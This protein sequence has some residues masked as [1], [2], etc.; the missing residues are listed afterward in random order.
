MKI[1]TVLFGAG[2]GARTF[3]ANTRETRCFVGVLDNDANKTGSQFEGLKV[4][5]PADVADL[6]F[7]EIVIT[8]QWALPVKKQL[9]NDIGIADHKVVIPAKHLLKKS[10]PFYNRKSLELG[11]YI[12]RSIS[13]LAVSRNCDLLVDFGTLLGLIRDKDI[14]EWDDDIDFAAPVSQCVE[15]EQILQD[16]IARS[17]QLQIDWKLEKVADANNVVSSLLL[18]FEANEDFL[19][20]TTSFSFREFKDGFSLHM[21]SLGMWHAPAC[22]FEQSERIAWRGSTVQVPYKYRD[23]LTFQYGKWEQPQ[24]NMSLND[25]ANLRDIGFEEI[26]GAGRTIRTITPVVS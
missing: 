26:R 25:Y 5:L 17:R 23:Y 13:D 7:D 20:F 14:I 19:P 15:V 6:N 16:F 2:P 3:M 24:K 4:S 18:N 8:T 21:P 10:Q 1:R 9:V 11:R 22:H 12:I